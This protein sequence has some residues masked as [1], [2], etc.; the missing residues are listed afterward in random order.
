MF[1]VADPPVHINT[2]TTSQELYNVIQAYVSNDAF[3]TSHD[4]LA[5]V[6]FTI[7]KYF[8]D[9]PPG[10]GLDE[11]ATDATINGD[12]TLGDPLG[13]A[14][15]AVTTAKILNLNVTESKLAT[16]AVTTG[17]IANNAVNNSKL[18]D[19]AVTT[20]KIVNATVTLAKLAQS[21][22]TSG[23]VPKW[24]GSAWAPAADNDTG[25]GGGAPV[26]ATPVSG[27]LT[28]ASAAGVTATRDTG[29]VT[30]TVP[31]GV[32]LRAFDIKGVLGDLNA[33]NFDIVIIGHVF[34]T[35]TNTVFPFI[36]M[37]YDRIAA[38]APSE[39]FPYIIDIDNTPGVRIIATAP[40]TYRVVNLNGIAN[41]GLTFVSGI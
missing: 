10:A 31:E 25:G 11:V 6:L 38:A 7:V 3:R 23:Q 13:L 26:M 16:S 24:N 20:S 22:A 9:V 27:V 41:W 5:Q 36:P 34:N 35:N 4:Q 15:D 21:G 18:A 32:Y 33:N 8:I 19:D 29:I 2:P 28:V 12:G 1:N 17:K 37:K 39:S 30:I 40:L 14:N